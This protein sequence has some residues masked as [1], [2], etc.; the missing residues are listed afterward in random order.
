MREIK[1]SSSKPFVGKRPAAQFARYL[2]NAPEIGAIYT[3]AAQALD[4]GDDA[5]FFAHLRDFERFESYVLEGT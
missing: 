1:T 5:A 2:M 3:G 4:A